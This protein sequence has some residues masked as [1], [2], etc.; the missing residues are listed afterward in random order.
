[1]ATKPTTVRVRPNPL[2]PITAA[3][4][5]LDLVQEAPEP[6]NETKAD[7]FKRIAQPR[8]VS[9]VERMRLLRKMFEGANA[10][11]Y[12]FTAEQADKISDTITKELERINELM[13][14]RLRDDKEK[15]DV[16]L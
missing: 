3:Q 10:N 13:D 15:I 7:R 16:E 4:T 5:E 14:A 6:E 11:N 9:I 1:M 2:N 12:A 8:L